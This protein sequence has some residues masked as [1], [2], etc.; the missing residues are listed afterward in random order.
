M[1]TGHKIEDYEKICKLGEG[2]FGKVFKARVKATGELVAL[3]K[4]PLYDTDDGVPCTTIREI[5][6]LKGLKHPNIVQLFDVIHEQSRMHLVFEYLQCDLHSHMKTLQEPLP[7]PVVKSFMRQLL[8]GVHFCHSRR[9]LHRDLKP[10]NLL[11]DL[12]SNKLKL[13]DFGLARAF[14]I[15]VRQYTHE[16]VTLWYRAPEILLGSMHYSTPVDVWSAGC[17]FAEMCSK[18]ALFPGDSEIN[19]LHRIFKVLGTPDEAVWP[20]VTSLRYWSD[21]FPQWKARPVS[22]W[23]KFVSGNAQDLLVR[24]LQLDPAK[25]IS[26]K[27]A[28]E[29][30]YFHEP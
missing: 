23:A 12:Q 22:E 18:R 5:S 30:P 25:R 9:V 19:Q 28:L 3:K 6:L 21:Q 8:E 11:L 7:A 26:A 14:G 2:T 4:V 24:M 16:V 29:H 20:G 10:Q 27:T 13:A 15:P 1:A 17:I